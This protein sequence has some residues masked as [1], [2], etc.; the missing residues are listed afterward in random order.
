MQSNT[1]KVM[2]GALLLVGLVAIAVQAQVNFSPAWGKRGPIPF[3]MPTQTRDVTGHF[4]QNL[5]D[6]KL[7]FDGVVRVLKLLQVQLKN[8]LVWD[9]S[10]IK[11]A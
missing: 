3:S 2:W 11:V 7:P 6:C 10:T 5:D 8:T 9:G 1:V 4:S